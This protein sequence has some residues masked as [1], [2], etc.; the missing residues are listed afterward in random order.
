MCHRGCDITHTLQCQNA[1][2]AAYTLPKQGTKQADG[3]ACSLCAT[4]QPSVTQSANDTARAYAP[5]P[6]TVPQGAS[7]LVYSAECPVQVV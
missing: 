2:T 4:Q 5:H 6:S 1:G 7:H 3:D